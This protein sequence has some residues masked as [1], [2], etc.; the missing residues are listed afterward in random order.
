[1]STLAFETIKIPAADLNGESSL[2]AIAGI[3]NVFTAKLTADDGTP[4]LR[5]YQFERIRRATYQMDFFLPEGSKMLLC[6]MRIVNP[7]AET[8]PMYWWSNIAVPELKNGRVVISTNE[9]FTNRGGLISKTGVPVSGGVDISYPVNN[10]YAVDYFWKLRGNTRKYICQLNAEGYGLAQTSTNTLKGRKLFVWGQGP[11]GEN[12]QEFLSAEGTGGKYAE[13]QAG[14]AHT[15][16]ECLPMP[17][18]TAWEWIEAYGAMNANGNKVHGDWED[19]KAEVE[20]RLSEIITEEQLEKML[21]DTRDTIAKRPA[22]ELIA[23]GDSWG[24]LENL[25][26]E[27]RGEKPISE[28]LEFGSI[29]CEQKQ[30]EFLLNNGYLEDAS[31]DEVPKSWMYQDEWTEMLEKAVLGPDEYNWYTWLQLGMIYFAKK[32]LREAK[33]ALDKSMKLKQSCWALYG[34]SNIARIEG[35]IEKAAMLVLRASLMKPDD[36]SLAKE[37]M[38][39]LLSAAM[40]NKMIDLTGQLSENVAG[41]GRIKLYKA[42]A[43]MIIIKI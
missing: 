26:R 13:I 39:A 10:A 15:Q 2:P 18:R 16:Y 11:G 4:V 20:S 23:S 21:V 14:L 43:Y 17:P 9:A 22:E 5:M 29:G 8:I 41:L 3:L 32:K 37:A 1:M 30:W 28:H 34:Q 36:A 35:N 19:A 24:A 33:E 7:N 27:K 31:P 42:F 12:W 6:R 25:R 40:Y 38:K